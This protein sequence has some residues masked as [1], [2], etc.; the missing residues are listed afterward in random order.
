MYICI[1]EEEGVRDAEGGPVEYS[2]SKPLKA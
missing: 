2:D 1:R